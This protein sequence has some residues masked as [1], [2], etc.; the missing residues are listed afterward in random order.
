MVRGS[1]TPEDRVGGLWRVSMGALSLLWGSSVRGPQWPPVPSL[2]LGTHRSF[3]GLA[4]W[5]G[6]LAGCARPWEVR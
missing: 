6:G 2:G 3:T 4:V 5:G 1:R